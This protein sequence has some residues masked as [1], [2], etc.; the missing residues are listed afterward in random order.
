MTTK[1]TTGGRTAE[2]RKGGREEKEEARKE[3]RKEEE[4]KKGRE[5][6]RAGDGRRGEQASDRFGGWGKRRIWQQVG[7]IEADPSAGTNL[8]NNSGKE[9]EGRDWHGYACRLQT[10][11]V[12]GWRRISCSGGKYNLYNYGQTTNF[13]R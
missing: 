9:K 6:G 1:T 2:G 13:F 5:G 8:K 12:G 11:A 3:A 4:R 10:D 7:G